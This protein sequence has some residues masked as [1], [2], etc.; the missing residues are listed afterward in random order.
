MAGLRISLSPAAPL[1]GR[2]DGHGSAQSPR[3]LGCREFH[4]FW[5]GQKG[6]RHIH[7]RNKIVCALGGSSDEGMAV[8]PKINVGDPY[9][10]LGIPRDASEEEIREAYKYLMAQYGWHDK[11]RTSIETA[12]D[13]ILLESLKS[14]RSPKIDV[15]KALRNNYAKLPPWVR[16]LSNIYDVPSSKVILIRAAFFTLLGVW[17]ALDQTQGGPAFQVAVSLVGCI[18]F[19]NDRLRSKWKALFAG[20]GSFV[21]GWV[22]GSVVASFLPGK[23]YPKSWTTEIITALISYVILWFSCTFF[24]NTARA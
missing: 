22:L 21:I 8:F 2:P 12:Y 23:L 7:H 13:K 15:Q 11:S 3:F 16:N 24:R 6:S 18:Y 4:L 5:P 17:S 19:L 14:R 20:I 1:V 9:K 10:R